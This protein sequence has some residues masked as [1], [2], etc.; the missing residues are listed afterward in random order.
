MNEGAYCRQLVAYLRKT[1]PDAVV[2][3]H[4]DMITAGTPDI[5]VTIAKTTVWL[6]VKVTDTGLNFKAREIQRHVVKRLAV[7]GWCA[8]VVFERNPATTSIVLPLA[9]DNFSYETSSGKDFSLVCKFIK[10]CM[11]DND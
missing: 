11:H 3:R 7:A 2:Q 8:Y 9:V 1:F 4:T 10:E 6:E 5:S